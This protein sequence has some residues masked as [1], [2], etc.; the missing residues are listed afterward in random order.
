VQNLHHKAIKTFNLDGII[1]DDSA[2]GR[3]KVELIKLKITEMRDLGYVVRLDIDPNFTI[4]YNE[5]KEY[6]EFKLTVYGTYIGKTKSK[7]TMGIDGTVLVP[8]AKNKLN[9]SSQGR[10][11]TLNQK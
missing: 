2:I 10:E 11:S 1:R 7:W 3:L 5:T 8:I 9:E 4:Q 6:F